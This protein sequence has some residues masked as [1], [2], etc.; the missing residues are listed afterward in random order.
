MGSKASFTIGVLVAIVVL[1]SSHGVE[2]RNLAEITTNQLKNA[3]K[4]KEMS[5]PGNGY[6]C[7]YSGCEKPPVRPI[8]YCPPPPMRCY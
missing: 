4:T 1:I 8:T 7:A 3:E 5:S 6:G 2:A